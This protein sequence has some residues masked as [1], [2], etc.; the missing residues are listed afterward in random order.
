[1]EKILQKRVLFV[2]LLLVAG[3][4]VFSVRLY[5]LQIVRH[6]ELSGIAE[7][8]RLRKLTLPSSRGGIVDRNGEAL[9]RSQPV[10]HVYGDRTR[11]LDAKNCARVVAHDEGVPLKDY[12]Q[13]YDDEELRRRSV[14][15]VSR[16]LAEVLG[17]KG[18]QLETTLSETSKVRF[19]V[20]KEL[21]H[22]DAERLR[23]LISERKISGIEFEDAM[24]RFY[25]NIHTLSHV[26]G[27]VNDR[28]EGMEGIEKTFD[29][30]LRGTDG[31]RLVEL[32]GDRREIAAYRA[33]NQP[34]VNGRTV[35]LTIDL[36][37]QT[38]LEQILDKAVVEYRPERLMA[39][40]MNPI[41]GE[42]LAM[43]SRPDF[44]LN[45]KAGNRKNLA[46]SHTIEPGSTL[47]IVS[48][49]A[50]YDLQ[51]VTPNTPIF[52]HN[53]FYHKGA[54]FLQDHGSYGDL[55]PWEILEKSSNIGAFML[56]KQVTSH[57]L[58][59]YMRDFGFGTK[60]GIDLTYEHA[61]VVNR[62][63]TTVN[64]ELSLSRVAMG[65]SIDVTPLQM[66]NAMA[67][68]ANGGLLMRPYIVD[69][70]TDADGR[71][72]MANEPEAIRRVV[73]ETAA[74]LVRRAMIEVTGENGTAKLAAIEGYTVAGKTGTAQKIKEDEK[75]RRVGYFNGKDGAPHRYVVSFGGFLPAENP[76]LVGIVVVD[77]PHVKSGSTFGGTV[78]AP[79]FREFAEAA[80]PY[81][82]VEPS[83]VPRRATRAVRRSVAVD[84]IPNRR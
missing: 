53:G 33:E 7:G 27:Y 26:L 79:I 35:S 78:A 72:V 52:C 77:D 25:P 44:N 51:L 30:H 12:R 47:K 10:A 82:G 8:E 49:A 43:A 68:I 71:V 75:G 64:E 38:R 62:P 20:S 40:F 70:V 57:T 65:Y 50:A 31:Y 4:S 83:R 66:V 36:G 69:R 1:M 37:L 54:V 42:I 21:A 23:A 16:T 6:E 19:A 84:Y 48:L 9:V 22:D 2:S 81:L 73:S 67:T 63:G 60:S 13:E 58:Y 76:A 32:G 41:T 39:V 18:Y 55:K 29:E 14:A 80:M 56:A 74:N 28:N 17:E 15:V 46:I 3:F 59:S 11:L 45:T 5:H 34:P 24:T 61:G